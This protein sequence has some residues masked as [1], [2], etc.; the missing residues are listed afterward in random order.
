MTCDLIVGSGWPFGAETL[1]P[2]E[3][4]KVVLV[5]AEKLEGPTVFETSQ[6]NIFNDVDPKVTDPYPSRTF[7]ILSLKLVPDPMSGPDQVIDLS[8]KKDDQLIKVDIPEGKHVFYALV[9][10]NSFASVISGAPG[11]AGPILNHMDENAVRKYLDHMSDTIQ[12]KTG[13]L[14][15]HLRALFTD[16]MELEGCNW[17]DDLPVEFKK[18]RGYDLMPYLPFILFKVGR[19]GLITDPNYGAAKPMIL[20]NS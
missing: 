14:S 13:P 11:A 3:R 10:V 2:D 18:R 6:F 1:K 8:E 17:N 15:N 16:S 5:Y 19:L 7:E 9:K 20:P 4:A 12:K